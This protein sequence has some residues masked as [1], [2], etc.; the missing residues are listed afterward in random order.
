[1][2]QVNLEAC[3]LTY[4]ID[5]YV[6][7]SCIAKSTKPNWWNSWSTLI[8]P[9]RTTH[10]LLLFQIFEGQGDFWMINFPQ[11]NLPTS[12]TSAIIGV[13]QHLANARTA[14]WPWP[15]CASMVTS[16][17]QGRSV[18]SISQSK[19]RCFIYLL[20]YEWYAAMQYNHLISE[21]TCKGYW[22]VSWEIDWIET[23]HRREW[24][25]LTQKKRDMFSPTPEQARKPI[26]IQNRRKFRDAN[27]LQKFP[28]S[29][30][31]MLQQW[32]GC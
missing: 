31:D 26:E 27:L 24:W 23:Q 16:F 4:L 1:M 13:V 21:L 28:S 20:I 15:L 2:N 29:C 9:K 10:D 7:I 6:H 3:S 32:N 5:L 22:R 19:M 14:S 18:F 12:P 17:F 11:Q 30:S 25:T 8:F